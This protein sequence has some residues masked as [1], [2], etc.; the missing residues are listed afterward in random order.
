MGQP[1]KKDNKKESAKAL[2]MT[3]QF[4]QKQIAEIV[5]T[6]P[7]TL[8]RWVTSEKWDVLLES[9]TTT[10]E[11]RI[12]KYQ[13]YLSDLNDTIEKRE[14]GARYPS[15]AEIDQINKLEATIKKLQDKSDL[16]EM[17]HFTIDVL[18]YVRSFDPDKAKELNDIFDAYIKSKV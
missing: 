2:Y 18:N 4:S 16:G 3:G 1:K 9:M 8:T 7:Q 17:V 14:E 12:A 13:Q 10:K 6:T 15:S 11:K 5:K